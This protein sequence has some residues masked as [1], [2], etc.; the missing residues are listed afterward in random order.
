MRSP[1]ENLLSYLFRDLV[2][3]NLWNVRPVFKT[4]RSFGKEPIDPLVS[5]PLADFE[6]HTCFGDCMSPREGKLDELFAYCH[7]IGSTPG[8][9]NLQKVRVLKGDW[10]S[11]LAYQSSRSMTYQSSRSET[12]QE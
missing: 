2:R 4:F 6:D 3:R 5:C 12:R 1:V 10:F 9:D 11:H 8:H 7:E